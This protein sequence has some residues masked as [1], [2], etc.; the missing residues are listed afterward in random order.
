MITWAGIDLFLHRVKDMPVNSIDCKTTDWLRD[1]LHQVYT[2]QNM[3]KLSYDNVL[4]NNNMNMWQVQ[5]ELDGF[6][7]STTGLYLKQAS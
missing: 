1:D 3:G 7:S 4:Q 5:L 6:K 2:H